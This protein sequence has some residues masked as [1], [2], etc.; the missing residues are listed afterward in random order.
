MLLP[1]HLPKPVF[2]L[3]MLFLFISPV[4]AKLVETEGAALIEKGAK[5][6]AREEAVKQAIRQAQLQ[7]LALVDSASMVVG[8]SLAVDSARVSAA[9]LVKD[10]VVIKEWQQIGRAHV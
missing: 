7:T 10:V 4:E 6:K 2:L 5:G 9:G 3:I 8:N 1:D